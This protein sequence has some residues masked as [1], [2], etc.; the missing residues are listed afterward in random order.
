MRKPTGR[1][2]FRN[3]HSLR[4]PL[5]RLRPPT[6]PAERPCGESHRIGDPD[7]KVGHVA[8][9]A[10]RTSLPCRFIAAIPSGQTRFQATVYCAKA[11]LFSELDAHASPRRV[12]GRDSHPCYVNREGRRVN[13]ARRPSQPRPFIYTHWQS[14]EIPFRFL[15]DRDKI[16]Q[17]I[18]LR[19]PPARRKFHSA[20]PSPPATPRTHP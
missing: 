8:S 17:I 16:N 13:R 10:P 6:Q 19:N 5:G 3:R 1:P 15:D 12:P 2:R 18:D 20:A 11:N 9:H 4:H 7:H 14:R